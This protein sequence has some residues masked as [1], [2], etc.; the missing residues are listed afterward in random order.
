MWVIPELDRIP[1]HDGCRHQIEAAGP[2]TLLL[3]T[4]VPNFPQSVEEH[5]SGQR[6]ACLALV[7]LGINALAQFRCFTANLIRKIPLV[8]AYNP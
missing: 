4:A 6:V 2:V 1:Q 7:W 8:W 5:G 3:K